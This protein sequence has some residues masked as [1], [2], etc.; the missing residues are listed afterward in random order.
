MKIIT[1]PL[2]PTS[3]TGPPA[4]GKF[5]ILGERHESRRGADVAH[6][7]GAGRAKPRLRER[8]AQVRAERGARP[9]LA[10]AEAGGE[11][12]CAAR[13][14]RRARADHARHMGRGRQH[15][16]MIGLFRKGREIGVAGAVPDFGAA[17]IHRVD[18]PGKAVAVEIAPDARRPA[19]RLV[20][21]ANQHDVPGRD[22]RAD[23]CSRSGEVQDVS[24]SWV[25]TFSGPGRA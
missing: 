20:A 5:A 1:P 3:A 14:R 9:A 11:D 25:R 24:S 6:A 2:C 13:A 8:R 4:K 17:G 23:P 22:K 12:R 19:S 15:H 7:I 10:F 21:G 16:E 18:R